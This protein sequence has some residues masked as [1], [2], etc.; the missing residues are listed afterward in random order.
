MRIGRL[1]FGIIRP[2]TWFGDQAWWYYMT[3]PCGCRIL[4]LGRIYLTWLHPDCKCVAC[5][6]YECEC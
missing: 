1:S 4:D 5:G 3:A 2:S 6:K